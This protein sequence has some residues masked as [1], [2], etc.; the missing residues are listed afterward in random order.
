MDLRREWLLLPYHRG[1]PSNRLDRPHL[2]FMLAECVSILKAFIHFVV[3]HEAH[4]LF[5]LRN[6]LYS[7]CTT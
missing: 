7:S 5:S 6:S 2:T 3:S 4:G 1:E